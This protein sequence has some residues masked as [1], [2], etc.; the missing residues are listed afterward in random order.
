MT[1]ELAQ[2]EVTRETYPMHYA[3]ADALGGAVIAFDTYQGPY[4]LI[5]EDIRGGEG[6]YA[7]APTGL[8]VTRLWISD[9]PIIYNEATEKSMP[10]FDDAP[11]TA[12]AA[13]QATIN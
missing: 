2:S 7:T 10:F 6:V 13:A 1:G 11:E 8:G 12:I 4:I 5:G 3:I 9:G